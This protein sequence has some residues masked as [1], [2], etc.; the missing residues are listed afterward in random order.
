MPHN[1]Q[2]GDAW[3]S[4]LLGAILAALFVTARDGLLRSLWYYWLMIVAVRA[5]GTVVGDLLAGRQ[6]L[7]L[8]TSTLFAGV[9]FVALLTAWKNPRRPSWRIWAMLLIGFAGIGFLA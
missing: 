8:P 5:A 6:V 4:L 3:A 2:L 7:G 9:L 1:L